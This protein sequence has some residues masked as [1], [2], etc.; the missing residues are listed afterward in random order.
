MGMW[1]WMKMEGGDEWLEGCGSRSLR[2]RCILGISRL[3]LGEVANR[4]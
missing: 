3:F 4:L 2:V 1:N